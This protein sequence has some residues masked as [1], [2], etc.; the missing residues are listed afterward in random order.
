MSPPR[1]PLAPNGEENAASQSTGDATPSL[2]R[3]AAISTSSTTRPLGS[4]HPTQQPPSLLGSSRAIG[5]MAFVGRGEG[6][7]TNVTR[8]GAPR[9]T[10]LPNH[11]IRR[12]NQSVESTPQ[13]CSFGL[14]WVATIELGIFSLA[15]QA[16]LKVTVV[17]E[18]VEVEQVDLK[19]SGVVAV[20]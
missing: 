17:A 7:S 16:P 4:I 6:T 18:E 20:R 9:M 1:P 13:V 12:K 8:Q 5:N 10:F 11:P 14:I 15:P 19:H 2:A 3:N